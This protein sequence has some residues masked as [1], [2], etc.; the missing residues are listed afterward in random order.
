MYFKWFIKSEMSNKHLSPRKW[1]VFVGCFHFGNVTT[2]SGFV[3]IDFYIQYVEQC[4]GMHCYSGVKKNQVPSKTEYIITGYMIKLEALISIFYHYDDM[5]G[6]RILYLRT[7]W[8][9]CQAIKTDAFPYSFT[10]KG[11][12]SAASPPTCF[13]EETR[14]AKEIH[15]TIKRSSIQTVTWDEH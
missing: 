11:N 10:P 13:S 6:W 15:T 8:T 12:F 4:Q 5:A 7:P 2:L 3:A 9:V 14:E 1:R